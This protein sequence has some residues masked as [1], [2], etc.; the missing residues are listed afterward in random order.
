MSRPLRIDIPD[1]WYHALS[2]GL[3]KRVIFEDA[4]DH[5]HFLELLGGMVGRYGVRLHAY[6]LMHNHYHLLIQTPQA[7]LSRAMQWLNVSYGVWFNKRHDRVGPLF[8]GRF[9][10][11]PVEAEGSW[12]LQASVYLHL[13]PVRIKGLGLGKRERKAERLGIL[14]PPSPEMVQ[15][16]LQALRMH[17]WSS[18]L[19]YAGYR[20]KPPV[21]LTC[22]NL[23]QRAKH[24]NLS[25]Q[26]SYRYDVEEPLKG[27]IQEMLTFGERLR[28]ALALGSEAFLDRLR[29]GVRGNRSTQ[30][31][32]RAWQ[33]LLPFERVVECVAEAKGEA[34][35]KFCNRRNDWGRDVALCL[36][37][38]HGGLTL[39]ELGQA[40][41]GVRVEAVAMAVR[42]MEQ[43]LL[44]DRALA[45]QV[46][47]MEESLCKVQT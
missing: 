13:N 26:E 38:R 36:G 37:R 21:W 32:V 8:Q 47:A 33:R 9:K 25:P 7:N 35:E 15:A 46:R 39:Q 29:R 44:Q 12:A 45:R 22:E 20:P 41:G 17:P 42:R 4:R 5:E 16:R 6:V 18:Y 24:R 14:P 3:G 1:G 27:G 28:T 23:W 2:R 19:D 11:V 43:R 34:W 10:A 30:P 31:A 40:A